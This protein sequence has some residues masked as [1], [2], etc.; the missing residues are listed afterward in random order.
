MAVGA[1]LKFA[2]LRGVLA[3]RVAVIGPIVE[4]FEPGDDWRWCS[5]DEQSV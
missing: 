2:T 1:V 3:A 4:S 5:V